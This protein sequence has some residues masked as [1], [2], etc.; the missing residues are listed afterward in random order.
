MSSK[1]IY[2]ARDLYIFMSNYFLTHANL[3]PI[4]PVPL[5][6]FLSRSPTFSQEGLATPVIL[7]W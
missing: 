3:S 7:N 6:S 1:L 2:S 5:K 4:P